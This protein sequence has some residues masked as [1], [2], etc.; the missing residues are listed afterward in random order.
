MLPVDRRALMLN[1]IANQLRYPNYITVYMSRT[2]VELFS[3]DT[4][5]VTRELIVRV[6]C[7][8]LQRT[9]FHPWGLMITCKELLLNPKYSFFE[10]S[11]LAKYPSVL[12][13]LAAYAEQF[14]KKQ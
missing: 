14:K 13:S 10:C 2:L 9:Q 7:E 4:T 1:A 6:L 12:K 11:F 8:R 5:E 3:S